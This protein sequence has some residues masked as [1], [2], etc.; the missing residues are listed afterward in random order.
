MKPNH[1][2]LQHDETFKALSLWSV[3]TR[4]AFHNDPYVEWATIDHPSVENRLEE[5]EVHCVRGNGPYRP[6]ALLVVENVH[7]RGSGISEAVRHD[8]EKVISTLKLPESDE[9]LGLVNSIIDTKS[10]KICRPGQMV[11]VTEILFSRSGPLPAI[12]CYCP[13]SP[14]Q[15]PVDAGLGI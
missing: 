10:M 13:G 6:R 11:K 5:R 14:C 15:K 2:G 1:F 3:K 8:V 4:E 9:G 12:S 7:G